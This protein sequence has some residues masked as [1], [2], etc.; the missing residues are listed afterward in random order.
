MGCLVSEYFI[1]W[2]FG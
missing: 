1:T 2:G